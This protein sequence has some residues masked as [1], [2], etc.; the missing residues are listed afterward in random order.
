M[1]RIYALLL[2]LFA[3]TASFGQG[4]IAGTVT[5]AKTKEAVI[6]ANVIIQGTGIGAATDVEGKFVIPKVAAG[7]YTLEISSVTY[8]KHVISNLVVEDAKRVTVDVPMAEDVSELQEVVVTS[9]RAYDTDFELLRSIKEMKVVVVGITSEQI[10]RTL[11]RDAAQVLKR[12]PG[13]TI[14]DEQFIQIRGVSERYNPVL[15]H[16][17]YAPSVETDVRSF[18]FATVPSSQL[19]RILVF[20]S[21]SPDLPGDF[22]GGVVKI[23]TKSIPEE[24]GLVV[25][26]STQYRAGTTFQDFYHQPRNGGH[27]TG[28]NTGYYSLPSDFPADASQV[29]GDNLV[30]AGRSLKNLWTPVKS[31]A[32]PDQRLNLTFNHKFHAGKVEIGNITALSYSNAYAIWEVQRGDYTQNGNTMDQNYAYQDKQ[33]NQAIRTGVLFNWA[34]RFNPSNTIEFKNLLNQSSFDQY[35]D[36]KGV[37]SSQGQINGSFDKVYRGIYSG[38]LMGTHELFN[39]Q[40]SVEWVAGYNK[41]YRDQPDYKRYQSFDGGGGMVQLNIPNSV[42]PIAL[43]RFYSRL[44]EEALSGGASIKQRFAFTNDPLRSPELKAG[45]F[46][47]NKSRTFN[48]RNI[49]YRQAPLFNSLSPNPLLYV[50]IG[51]L[52]QPENINNTTGIRLGE[53]SDPKD[54]YTASNN[55][56]AYYLMATIPL[57]QKFKIDGGVRLE[58]NFQKMTSVEPSSLHV[59][60]ALPSVNL[61]YNFNEKMLVRTAYGQTLNRPEFRELAPFTFYDFNY[62]FLYSGQPNLKTARIQTVDLRWE[63]YPTKTEMITFGGFYKIFDNPIEPY[64]SPSSPGGGNKLITYENSRSATVYGIELEVKKSLAGLTASRFLNNVSVIFNSSLTKSVVQISANPAFSAGRSAERPL[65]G[66]APYVVNAGLF[67][68]SE[69]SGWQV[70]ALYNVV[71]KNV[72]L[73]GTDFYRDVYIMPRN[74]VDLTFNKRVSSR[75]SLKG[76]ITDILNQP[77]LLLQDGNGDKKLDRK[78]DQVIQKFRPGQV[79]SIGVIARL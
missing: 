22:G 25:D 38:Q 63:L 49:G 3:A 56:L 7:T 26:Y 33:Y 75:V 78:T 27:F 55:L 60:R 68:S 15:L 47:E 6:G 28:I 62:N 18:S 58:D 40:T 11:D 65:Q 35:V 46:F 71:G 2:F 41:T 67:Y 8:K 73:V 14:K 44:D 53:I 17:A 74:V 34:F 36:R 45:I 21:A 79:F 39:K 51:E 10:S 24:N 77:M 59:V 19:D 54:S 52:F 57:G 66:Q 1:L 12:V 64:V 72:F 32:I 37:E 29:S 76:G 42:T 43:G 69:E 4:S 13:I 16:N 48:A 9:G 30:N 23:F 31:T 70:N 61:S 20:K 50:P 5:D